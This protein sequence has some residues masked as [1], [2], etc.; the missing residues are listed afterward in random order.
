MFYNNIIF[1]YHFLVITLLLY[2]YKIFILK[3]NFI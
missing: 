1:I 2:F 3:D